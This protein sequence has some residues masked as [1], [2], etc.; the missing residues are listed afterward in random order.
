MKK[1]LSLILVMMLACGMLTAGASYAD[2]TSAA[3]GDTVLYYIPGVS[4]FY[5]ANANCRAVSMTHKP[6]PASFTLAEANDEAYSSLKP[7][8]A[9]GAPK[10]LPVQEAPAA[11][12]PVVEA[13]AAETTPAELFEYRLND[14]G[15]A[16]ITGI[17]DEKIEILNIPAELDGH[18]VTSIE[19][20]A[21]GHC[22]S[23]LSVAIPEGVTTLGSHAFA[24]CFRLESV[25]IPDS[26]V[27]IGSHALRSE[28]L[29]NVQVS[30][31]HPVFAVENKALINKQNMKLVRFLGPDITG[32]YEI[33]QGI[34]TIGEGAFEF[35]RMSSV[36]I[37]DSVTSVGDEAFCFCKE[38]KTLTFP[39]S[40]TSVGREAFY[41]CFDLESV[42]IP[43]SVTEI[44]DDVFECCSSLTSIQI[45]PDHPVYE[46]SDLVLVN[47]EEK[48]I[49]GASG[50]LSGK[51]AVP[52]GILSIADNAFYG[53]R[54]LK[55]LFIPESVT[56]LGDYITWEDTVI[57]AC[58]GSAAQRYCEEHSEVKFREIS[59]KDFTDTVQ[60]LE[61][62][63]ANEVLPESKP[64]SQYSEDENSTRESGMFQYKV[65]WDGTVRITK[66]N[67][68]LTDGNIPAEL[69]GRK[70]TSI[71][72]DAFLDCASLKTVVIP[73]GVE[74]VEY[75]AFWNCARLESISIPASV[76][77]MD[78][79]PIVHCRNLKTIDISPDNPALEMS[80]G[81]LVSKQS[82]TLVYVL[83]HKDTGTYTVSQ[84]IKQI[85]ECAFENCAFS[86]I[87]LPEG[88]TDIGDQAFSQCEN[89][90]DLV[91]PE[92]VTWIGS[93]AFFGANKLE[94]VTIPD[95]V[96]GID[97]AVFGDNKALVTVNISPDHPAFEMR[98]PLL[99]NRQ[100]G[101]IVSALNNTPA[102]YEIPEGIKEIGF[103]G[104]QGSDNLTELIVPEGVTE[105]GVSAFSG[106][107]KLSIITLPASLTE[108][109]N[110]AFS[111]SRE[112]LIRAPEGSWAQQYAEKHGYKFEAV[113][114]VPEAAEEEPAQE[115]DTV[116]V[117]AAGAAPESLYRYE[118]KAD[119]TAEITGVDESIE[120]GNIPAELDGHKVT[121]IGRYVF[122][123]CE[124][125]KTVVIPEGVVSVGHTSFFR[126][127]QLESLSIPASVVS[128]NSSPVSNC[129]NLKTIEVSPDNPELEVSDGALINKLSRTLVCILDHEDTGTYTVQ[130]GI[131]RI[132]DGAFADCAFS[133]IILPD[134]ITEI[135][136]HTFE[137][138]ENL[139]E[140][141][142]PEGVTY[143]GIQAFYGSGKLESV[144]IPDSVTYIGPAVFGDN[145][146]LTTVRI[147]PDHPNFKMTDYLLVDKR[148]KKVLSVLNSVPAEYE[149]PEGI[150]KIC[151]LGFQG[152]SGLTE[153]IVPEGV[154]SIGGSA[155]NGCS[156]LSIVTLPSSMQEISK[157]AFEYCHE[158]L[159]KAPA[160]SYAQKY[161]EEHGYKFEAVD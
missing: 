153:L 57:R 120:D 54:D 114:S 30:P 20:F 95:S 85:G 129:R 25:S 84:G 80:N 67:E 128:M 52:D 3:A 96:T 86:G 134:G 159:I 41:R 132:G 2:N 150:E 101:R 94:S 156:N 71:G 113:D 14:D 109:G 112:L 46:C 34:R 140:L 16:E 116:N 143:I 48:K 22:G 105:I 122:M 43:D 47:R 115:N 81:A 21:F 135:G 50:V 130:Q 12:V 36:I 133:D 6:L 69:D 42:V 56:E 63:K 154:T 55:E 78:R 146:A 65:K 142:L 4:Q 145:M 32:T 147:S 76:V 24:N 10:R 138:C 100:E 92:G 68:F 15:T 62:E 37:P 123:N 144:T 5:H 97:S 89:L 99:V 152:C 111:Y 79:A 59:P 118:V 7:C 11:E 28:R 44:G 117:T 127:E 137:D 161:A 17:S 61:R 8:K 136:S 64:V 23:L 53:C 45:S 31:D 39:D 148:E 9:C 158:L 139:K 157:D 83:D 87:S 77:Y 18:Q 119:G 93:Q 33:A 126:C 90:T 151:T 104:F 124:N 49:I 73:E 102:K 51:Y 88:I 1:L 70:V 75:S 108:I 107:E 149:I 82:G 60:Q 72:M 40:V 110:E 98:G 66:A 29:I 91:I 58:A 13:T 19:V 131:Q 160:G 38:L 125:L 26:L 103:M 35:G 27:N 106:C 121:S 141:V 74:S 155:F